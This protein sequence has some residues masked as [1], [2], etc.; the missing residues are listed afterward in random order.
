MFSYA[1]FE[2]PSSKTKKKK[3]KNLIS[4]VALAQI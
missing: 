1:L 4:F 2:T 3:K